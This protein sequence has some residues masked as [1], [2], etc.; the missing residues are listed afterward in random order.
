[1]EDFFHVTS[2]L[3]I[4][5]PIVAVIAGLIIKYNQKPVVSPQII[6]G[7]PTITVPLVPTAI[8]ID[9]TGP[10]VCYFSSPTATI[11]AFIKDKKI[12]ANIQNGQKSNNLIINGDC[13]YTYLQGSYS[14][15]KICGISVLLNLF[16]E[17]PSNMLD[18]AMFKNMI[19]KSISLNSDEFKK[20]LNSCKKENIKD[21][22]IFTVP[23][24][25]LFK[26]K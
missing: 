25:I 13:L 22:T 2:R 1:M 6:S 26:N 15:E 9:L 18:N 5:V 21:E 10:W 7:S 20:G 14:G 23:K 19:T 16:N 12:N 24:N 4:V 3:I 11:S 8:P 17:I